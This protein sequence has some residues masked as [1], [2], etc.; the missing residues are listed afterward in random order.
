MK[1]TETT[2]PTAEVRA[3]PVASTPYEPLYRQ[4]QHKAVHPNS[5]ANLRP[6][7]QKGES[8]NP[9]GR[10]MGSRNRRSLRAEKIGKKV[11]HELRHLIDR[12][13]RPA[14]ASYSEYYQQRL[15]ALT[16]DRRTNADAMQ[17]AR[18]AVEAY[19]LERQSPK[20]MQKG[21]LC[22]RCGVR[23]WTSSNDVL[24]VFN[25]AGEVAWF[26]SNCVLPELARAV[27]DTMLL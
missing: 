5:R 11:L 13:E 12:L 8:G 23:L 19:V 22:P 18:L 1:M 16:A 6:P 27:A 9:A 26:H 10:R 20:S 2:T 24:A 3:L 17:I 25:S 14:I 4:V 7:W 15:R 21:H